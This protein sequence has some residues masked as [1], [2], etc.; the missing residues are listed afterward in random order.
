[1]ANVPVP[2]FRI[3]GAGGIVVAL[4]VLV[5]FGTLHLLAI[6]NPEKRFAKVLLSLGF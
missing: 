3:S 1:M 2:V 4:Y 5:V 6:S